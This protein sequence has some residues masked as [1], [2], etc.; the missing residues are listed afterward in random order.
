[1]DL[2]LVSE[3]VRLVIIEGPKTQISTLRGHRDHNIHRFE[4]NLIFL[5]P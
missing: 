4:P 5:E 2:D 1:M 3:I